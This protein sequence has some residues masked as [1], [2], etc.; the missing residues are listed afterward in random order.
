MNI[1]GEG[2]CPNCGHKTGPHELGS[3]IAEY[4]AEVMYSVCSTC[5]HC[6]Q[7]LTAFS[8]WRVDVKIQQAAEVEKSK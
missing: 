6:G 4:P 8:V 3:V 2:A 5:E 1:F 7:E